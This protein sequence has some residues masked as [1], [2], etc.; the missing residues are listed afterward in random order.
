LHA[1]GSAYLSIEASDS[2]G[3][4]AI[5]VA[6]AL[7]PLK[8]NT[9]SLRTLSQLTGTRERQV[10]LGISCANWSASTFL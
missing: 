2:R 1:R 8:F 9:F 3:A 10:V 7:H 6:K 5:G 4:T